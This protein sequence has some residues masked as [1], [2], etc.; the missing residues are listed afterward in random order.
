[1][2]VTTATTTTAAVTTSVITIEVI[3]RDGARHEVP[4]EEDQVLMEALRDNDLPVLASC[5]GSASC[6]TC[7]VF[8]PEDIYRTLPDRSEDEVDLVEEAPGYRPESSRLSCQIRHDARLEGM[9]VILAPTRTDA[10]PDAWRT[11]T[12]APA[13]V[14]GASV[15]DGSADHGL[16]QFHEEQDRSK[17][18]A[19]PGQDDRPCPV[20]VLPETDRGEYQGDRA[21]DRHRR[22]DDQGGSAARHHQAAVEPEEDPAKEHEPEQGRSDGPPAEHRCW[23]AAP[24]G[25]AGPEDRP[26][27]PL[28]DAEA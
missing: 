8:V 16:A 25:F 9:T 27:A 11:A 14:V 7:H 5:G 1:M 18:A 20:A 3:D 19:H 23:H 24:P 21:G 22:A 13:P 28:P 10:S 26:A 6:A 12:D 15:R 2:P 17:E 4:W